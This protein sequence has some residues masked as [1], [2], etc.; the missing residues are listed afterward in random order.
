MT[1]P[2]PI[3]RYFP[4]FDKNLFVN[5]I[6]NLSFFLPTLLLLCPVNYLTTSMKFVQ[7]CFFSSNDEKNDEF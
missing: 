7:F 3:F 1:Q 6:K 4:F 5:V 2:S